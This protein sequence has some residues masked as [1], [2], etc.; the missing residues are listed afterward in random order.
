MAEN[1]KHLLHVRSNQLNPEG[2]GPKLPTS[3]Q[4]DYGE[5]A[6]NYSKG[7]EKISFKNS[8]NEIVTVGTDEQNQAKLNILATG[9]NKLSEECG[10]DESM[11]YVPKNELISGSE[12]LSNALEVIADRLAVI[13]EVTSKAFNTINTSCGFNEEMTYIPKNELIQ[14]STS[15]SE[16]LETISEKVNNINI[17]LNNAINYVNYMNSVGTVDSLTN[18]PTDKHLL[19]ANITNTT[20]SLTLNQ[21]LTV[22]KELHIIVY[23]TSDANELTITL[24][25]SGDFVNI[26]EPTITILPLGYGEINIV[27]SGTKMYIRAL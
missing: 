4:I 3:E 19:I 1:R 17:N 18:V 11:N 15:L 25:S 21:N 16:S 26:T 8:S 6:I 7:Y 9:I 23:N 22:G 12:N 20:Q 14:G 5:L 2:N 13:D 10:F 27:S 24:P